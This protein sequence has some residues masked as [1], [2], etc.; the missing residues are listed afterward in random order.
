[1]TGTAARQTCGW[2]SRIRRA[3]FQDCSVALGAAAATQGLRRLELRHNRPIRGHSRPAED[4]PVRSSKLRSGVF[5]AA[6]KGPDDTPVHVSERQPRSGHRADDRLGRSSKL[7]WHTQRHRQ[8]PIVPS[9]QGAEE[10]PARGAGLA[11]P[12]RAE[13]CETATPRPPRTPNYAAPRDGRPPGSSRAT[14]T[15]LRTQHR[16]SP[17]RLGGQPLHTSQVTKEPPRGSPNT[18]PRSPRTPRSGR[19]PPP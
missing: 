2:S 9:T 3:A 4:R 1:L 15:G 19:D 7:R 10:R 12:L 5:K 16:R 18:S 13:R 6:F 14:G 17:R 8:R 11:A